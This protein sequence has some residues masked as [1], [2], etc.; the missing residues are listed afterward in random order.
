MAGEL[1]LSWIDRLRLRDGYENV[2][3]PGYPRGLRISLLSQMPQTR[4]IN[5]LNGGQ[6]VQYS[7]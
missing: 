1:F 7:L 6:S 3:V 2:L 4:W 5:K